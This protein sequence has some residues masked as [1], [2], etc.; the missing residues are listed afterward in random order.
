MGDDDERPNWREIDRKRDK[1]RHSDRREQGRTLEDHSDRWRSGRVKEA[2]DRVLK[3]E[4]GTAEHDKLLGKVDRAYGT[5]RFLPAV[6]LYMERY[7]LPD[8][9]RMLLLLLDTRDPSICLAAIEKLKEKVAEGK[10]SARQKEDVRRKLSIAA[11]A[12]TSP[13]VRG[14]AE[15]A[16]EEGGL[17]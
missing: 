12:D 11:L 5:A 15:A 6:K 9:V 14:A 17:S 4:K 8:D 10:M 16:I 3:G 13:E 7:G 1:S 2:L